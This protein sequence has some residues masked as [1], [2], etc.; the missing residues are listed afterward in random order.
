VGRVAD[1]TS[2]SDHE[3]HSDENKS[4]THSS[5]AEDLDGGETMDLDEDTDLNGQD[6]HHLHDIFTAE[7]C[8][9]FNRC[10]H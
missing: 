1:D 4:P 6:P 10:S 2:S 8:L 7:V 3:T 9:D 5:H